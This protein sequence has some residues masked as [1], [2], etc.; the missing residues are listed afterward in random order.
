MARPVVD[1]D[2][3]FLKPANKDSRKTRT[4]NPSERRVWKCKDGRRQFSVLTGTI[5]H[6]SKVSLRT[7]LF[8]VV[9]MCANRTGS[10]LVKLSV[11]TASTPRP[12]GS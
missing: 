8:V 3:Y 4:G 1:D 12:R 11:S 9:E 2:H 7:W 6:C 10:P 5:F